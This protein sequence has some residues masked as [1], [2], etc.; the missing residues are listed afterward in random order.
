MMSLYLPSYDSEVTEL[1]EHGNLLCCLLMKDVLRRGQNISGHLQPKH[2][3]SEG[4]TLGQREANWENGY[5]PKEGDTFLGSGFVQTPSSWFL[6]ENKMLNFVY[7]VETTNPRL[8]RLKNT[9]FL[10]ITNEHLL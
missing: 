3:T 7:P 6:V 4:D 10:S 9:Y 1:I 2:P 8:P 5:Y